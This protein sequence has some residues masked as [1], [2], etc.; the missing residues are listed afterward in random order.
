M[1]DL[2][3]TMNPQLADMLISNLVTNA[4]RHSEPH[5]HILLQSGKNIFIISNSRQ[6]CVGQ[7]SHFRS[8]LENRTF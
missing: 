4:I 6:D 1:N 7:A 3:V 2:Q 5:G 8:F